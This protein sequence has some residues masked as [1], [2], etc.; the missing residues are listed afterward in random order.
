MTLRREVQP[1]TRDQ[2][3]GALAV[4]LELDAG[5]QIGVGHLLVSRV[6]LE[7]ALINDAVLDLIWKQWVNA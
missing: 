2:L 1:L 6:I 3:R 7:E 4:K 5:D